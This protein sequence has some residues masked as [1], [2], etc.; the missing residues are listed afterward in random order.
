M[1]DSV[2]G[3]ESSN[4]GGPP[5]VSTTPGGEPSQT[6][7][8]FAAMQQII[9]QLNAANAQA[10]AQLAALQAHLAAFQL[11]HPPPPAAAMVDNIFNGG[12]RSKRKHIKRRK[13][14]RSFFGFR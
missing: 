5:S 1:E 7:E 10:A 9:N 3:V 14:N 12:R 4:S 13:T 11:N 8:Q 6:A 2:E